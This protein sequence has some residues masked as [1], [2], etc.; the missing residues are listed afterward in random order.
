[1][2]KW[3]LKQNGKNCNKVYELKNGNGKIQ[4]YNANG[5]IKI[6]GEYKNGEKHGKIKEYNY[7]GGLLF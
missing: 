4:G 1:M 2:K 5:K 6:I 3:N 7:Y